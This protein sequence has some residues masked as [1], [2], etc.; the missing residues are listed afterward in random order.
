MKKLDKRNPL[1][2]KLNFFLGQGFCSGNE[3]ETVNETNGSNGTG[4]CCIDITGVLLQIFPFFTL[5]LLN[6][7]K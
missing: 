2:S 4:S 5:F 7:F 1:Q 3:N 6:K